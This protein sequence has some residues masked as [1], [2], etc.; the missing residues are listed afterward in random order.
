[1][2]CER[3]ICVRVLWTGIDCQLHSVTSSEEVAMAR[4]FVAFLVSFGWP[5]APRRVGWAVA[6]SA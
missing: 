5:C 6:V 4:R 1:M 2:C 3:T